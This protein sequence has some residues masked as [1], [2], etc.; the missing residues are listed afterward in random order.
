MDETHPLLLHSHNFLFVSILD[1]YD[2]LD[3]HIACESIQG[4]IQKT[5]VSNF[6]G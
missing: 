4:G 2:S 3:L 6:F 5:A 1:A